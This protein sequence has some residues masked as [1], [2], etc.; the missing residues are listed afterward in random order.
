MIQSYL[1]PD[2]KLYSS[3]LALFA[4]FLSTEIH[5]GANQLQ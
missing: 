2:L 4:S 5:I 3:D 1:A